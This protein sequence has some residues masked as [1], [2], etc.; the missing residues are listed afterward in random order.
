MDGQLYPADILVNFVEVDDPVI[1]TPFVSLHCLCAK[2][3]CRGQCALLRG[4]AIRRTPV[5]PYSLFLHLA[6]HLRQLVPFPAR[7]SPVRPRGRAP[8]LLHMETP[9]LS[10]QRL[11]MCAGA[12]QLCA[13]VALLLPWASQRRKAGAAQ[14]RTRCRPDARRQRPANPPSGPPTVG[15]SEAAAAAHRGQ[16][17]HSVGRGRGRGGRCPRGKACKPSL[18]FRGPLRAQRAP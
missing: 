9:V 1:K 2:L 18:T 6:I 15:A 11:T 12:A 3:N 14:Q 4:H 16:Q 5:G 13:E 7:D 17:W 10:V 8:E